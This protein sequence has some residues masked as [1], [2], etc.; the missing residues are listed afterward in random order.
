MKASG[1]IHLNSIRLSLKNGH[2]LP[3][4]IQCKQMTISLSYLNNYLAY[5][6]LS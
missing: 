6:N 4:Q 5:H 1:E 2:F 3:F